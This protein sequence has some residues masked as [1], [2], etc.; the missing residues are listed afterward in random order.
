MELWI[1]LGI[2]LL[3]VII[4]MVIYNKMVVARNTYKNALSQIEVSLKQRH[5]LI[6]TLVETV[7]GYVKHERE[8]LDAIVSARNEATNVRENLGEM[9]NSDQMGALAASEKRLND[10]VMKIFAL[11]EAY[12]DLKASDNFRDLQDQISRLEDKISSARRGYNLTVLEYNNTIETVP[13]NIVAGVFKFHRAQELDFSSEEP[14][15]KNMP[16]VSF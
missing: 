13:N 10:G 4:L 16:E 5:D 2:T 14:D 12:P 15:I 9:P 3:V 8:T 6:P 7:K 11:S 1:G